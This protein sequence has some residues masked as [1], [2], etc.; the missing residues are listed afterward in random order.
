MRSYTA[1]YSLTMR[2][3]AEPL[4]RAFA[5]AAAIECEHGRELRHHRVEIVEDHAGDALVDDFA[6]G[7]AIERGDRRAA[8]HRFG[9]HQA[10]RL[11]RLN[12]IEQRARAAVQLHLRGEV[13]FAEINNL[14][15]VHVRRDLLAVVVVFGRRENELHADAL[16]DLDRLQHAFAFREAAEEEQ[17]VLG[18]LAE[19]EVVGVDAVQHRADDVGAGEEHAPAPSEIATNGASG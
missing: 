17:V 18:R 16:G 14:R 12:R 9:E 3:D 8:R 6:D 1:T 5:D 4:D 19:R 7:A 13:R 10:E 2:C 11:A 15:A